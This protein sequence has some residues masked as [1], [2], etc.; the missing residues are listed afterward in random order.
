M[1]A[2]PD[3]KNLDN[4]SKIELAVTSLMILV[5]IIIL[6]NSIKSIWIKIHPQRPA[7]VAENAAVQAIAKLDLPFTTAKQVVAEAGR[8]RDAYKGIDAA[9]WGRDPFS[10]SSSGEAAD[11]VAGLTLEGILWDNTSPSAIINGEFVR[12]GE[13]IGGATVVKINKDS[14]LVN[15]GSKNYKL[16]LW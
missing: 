5:F 14:V 13:K 10:A 1:F 6:L 4:K 9:A 2:M 3:F 11:S 12:Q 15:D 8:G 16:Q 7:A